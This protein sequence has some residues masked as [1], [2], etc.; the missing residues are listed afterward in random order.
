MVSGDSG[1]L[2]LFD[3]IRPVVIAFERFRE[4]G[5]GGLE[6]RLMTQPTSLG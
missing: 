3:L 6:C 5:L 1:K 2:S 4:R